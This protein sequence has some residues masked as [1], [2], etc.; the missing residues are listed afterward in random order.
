MKEHRNALRTFLRE[1]TRVC[2]YARGLDETG[3]GPLKGVGE[4]DLK[5]IVLNLEVA[6][7]QVKITR[8]RGQDQV[9]AD[10]VDVACERSRALRGLYLDPD[11]GDSEEWGILRRQLDGARHEFMLEAGRLVSPPHASR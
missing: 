10:T 2:S 4:G 9:L 5:D 6:A 3:G 8:V 1:L 7:D 11:P